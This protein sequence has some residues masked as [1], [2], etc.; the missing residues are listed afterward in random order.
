MC[1]MLQNT[2]HFAVLI[3]LLYYRT[4]QLQWADIPSEIRALS[5]GFETLILNAL[6]EHSV[7]VHFHTVTI[8]QLGIEQV[9][10]LS[11]SLDAIHVGILSPSV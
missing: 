6:V 8:E 3:R 2:K 5:I 7:H 1:D 4:Y 11:T 10:R 9:E